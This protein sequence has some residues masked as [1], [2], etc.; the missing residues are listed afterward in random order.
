M[1]LELVCF[2]L[3]DGHGDLHCATSI[4]PSIY[5]GEQDMLVEQGRLED[6]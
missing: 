6:L 3:L 2:A 1:T 4:H 5:P